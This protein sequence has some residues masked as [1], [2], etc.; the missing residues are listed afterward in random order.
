MTH[1]THAALSFA[2]RVGVSV[3]IA[4][5]TAGVLDLQVTNSRFDSCKGHE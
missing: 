2:S 4:R 3:H 5:A 1:V